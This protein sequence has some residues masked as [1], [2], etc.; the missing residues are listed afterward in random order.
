MTEGSKHARILLVGQTVADFR[1]RPSRN[2]GLFTVLDDRYEI[3]GT[4]EPHLSWLEEVA[5]RLRYVRPNR[6][7]WRSRAGLSPWAFRRLT[8]AAERELRPWDGR[9][10]L[11][12]LVQTLFAPG[13]SPQK[14][15]YVV[16]TDNIH[17]L[18]ARYFPAWAPLGR[19]DRATRIQL[20]Q[21]TCRAA[22]YVLAKSDF[23]RDSLIEDYGCEPERVVN[24]GSGSNIMVHSLDGKRYDGKVALFVG[25]DF[26]RKGGPVLLR[27][28][29]AV[30]ER[31]PDAELWVV[32][33]KRRPAAAEQPGVRWHGFVADRQELA[34]LYRRA[35]LFVLPSLFEPLGSVLL[36][37]RGHGLACI[38]TDRGSFRESIDDGVDGLLVPAGEPAPLAEALVSLLSD[39]GRA[40]QMGRRGHA[41]LLAENTWERVADRMAPYLERAAA[42]P[43]T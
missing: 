2:S 41:E 27:A 11:I 39:P 15:R 13:L 42:E 43:L 4:I 28:W 34:D 38:G 6:D 20:E 23:L 9:H 1:R 10:D 24:V 30:R 31:V 17:V 40:A 5:I 21:A 3:A 12:M 26:E 32:G 14:R 29:S 19:R 8:A 36:E 37:A 7:A 16:Y 25:I 18:T 22:R 33:P 35:T